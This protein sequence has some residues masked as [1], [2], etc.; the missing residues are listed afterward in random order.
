MKPTC[1]TGKLLYLES[2]IVNVN[3]TKEFLH[4][5]S[6]PNTQLGAMAG[7]ADTKK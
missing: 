1:I 4:T 7:Q 5:L 6:R 3:H 2:V